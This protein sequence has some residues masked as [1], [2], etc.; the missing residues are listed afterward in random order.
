MPRS[1]S[2]ARLG[3][4]RSTEDICRENP[5]LMSIHRMAK[6]ASSVSNVLMEVLC[7]RP[8]GSVPRFMISTYPW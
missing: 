4:R 6:F 3:E 7:Y 2:V 8:G 5:A 1:P